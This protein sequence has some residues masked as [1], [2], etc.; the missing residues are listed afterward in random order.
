LTASSAKPVT[1]ALLQTT[2]MYGVEWGLIAAVS[3]LAVLPG[4]VLVAF[5]SKYIARGFLVG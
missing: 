2:S 3:L 1:V 4:V 5:V